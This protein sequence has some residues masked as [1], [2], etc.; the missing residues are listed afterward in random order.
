[1][2]TSGTSTFNYN[3]DQIIRA[4][5]RK[6][7]AIQAGEIPGAQLTQDCAD[8][9]NSMVKYWQASGIH[10]WTETEA[11][12]YTQVGQAQYPLGINTPSQASTIDSVTSL[13]A[14]A[15]AGASSI[16]VLSNFN[17]S[18]GIGI[19]IVLDSGAVFWTTVASF[20]STTITLTSPLTDSSTSGNLVYI[21]SPNIVRP[22]R[23]PTARRWNTLSQIETPLIPLSKN[24]YDAL[25]NKNLTGTVTQWYYNPQGGANNYGV[26]YLWPTP[27]DVV[28]NNI[29]FM[30][31]RPIQDFN[32][33][34]NTPDLPQEWINTL[35]WNL[36]YY[37]A[38]EFG[39]PAEVFA[40]VKSMAVETL[41]DCKGWDKEPEPTYFGVDFS[42]M[43]S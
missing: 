28:N 2:T 21:V 32:T 4:A 35:I 14:N 20:V 31:Y 13:T 8:Q 40:M 36:A 29:K 27:A 17:V 12:L 22:L 37:M 10:I 23:I 33:A 5:L 42:R 43:G 1:M 15:A 41:E 34:G 24:D 39:C 30:F 6:I 19:G 7:G 26:M 9:L 18:N 3:R 38:P 16:Q 11:I 25:P